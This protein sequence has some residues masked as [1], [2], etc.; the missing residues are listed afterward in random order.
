MPSQIVVRGYGSFGDGCVVTKGYSC[1]EVSARSTEVFTSVT[2]GAPKNNRI[3]VFSGTVH[4]RNTGENKN[5]SSDH[6]ANEL[7][8]RFDDPRYYGRVL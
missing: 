6:A 8:G 7:G 3:T 2:G 4:Y 1:G 5:A